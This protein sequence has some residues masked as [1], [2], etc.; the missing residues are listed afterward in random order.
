M[1]PKADYW[2][3]ESLPEGKLFLQYGIDFEALSDNFKKFNKLVDGK[4]IINV[5]NYILRTNCHILMLKLPNGNGALT[6]KARQ[7]PHYLY[8]I[9]RSGNSRITV[10]LLPQR[11]LLSQ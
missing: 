2:F 10:R 11:Y 1:W 4:F 3:W 6:T 8:N 7:L 9:Q 5:E